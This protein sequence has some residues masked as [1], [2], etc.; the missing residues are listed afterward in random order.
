SSR[1][2]FQIF[3]TRFEE[4][5]EASTKERFEVL[6]NRLLDDNK[7][8]PKV[9]SYLKSLYNQQSY[10]A[11]P[12]IKSPFTA[13]L[14]KTVGDEHFRVKPELAMDNRDIAESM[15]DKTFRQVLKLN[16]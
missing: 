9:G 2:D 13:A 8:I 6:W 14:S 15:I 5:C 12:W 10:W 1:L 3:K 7:E 16:R 4:V 11:G